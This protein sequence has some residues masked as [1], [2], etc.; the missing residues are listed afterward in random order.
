MALSLFR[1]IT[2][3][4][5]EELVYGKSEGEPKTGKLDILKDDDY[6]RFAIATSTL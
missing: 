5:K 3:A 6:D 2:P 1:K 4:D